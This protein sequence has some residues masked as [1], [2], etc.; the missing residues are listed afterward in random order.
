MDE[1]VEDL[2]GEIQVRKPKT[3]DQP[4]LYEKIADLKLKVSITK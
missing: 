3:S 2:R 4:S 1:T